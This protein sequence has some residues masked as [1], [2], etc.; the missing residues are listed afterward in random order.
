MEFSI[1]SH[2]PA[3]KDTVWGLL[4]R[5]DTLVF[6]A[7]GMVTY[8]GAG[9]FP[10]HWELDQPVNL[11]PS[12]FGWLPPGDHTVTFT[13][14]Q[15]ERGVLQTR[16]RGGP[17]KKW[18]H[19]MTVEPI[20]LATCRYTDHIVFDAGWLNPLAHVFVR[21]FYRHRHR[22]WSLL[23]ERERKQGRLT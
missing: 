4:Q 2:L 14:R 5:S 22:R 19:R 20:D 23:L 15:P 8:Q 12:L 16:E 6:L 17:F 18:N 9:G 13:Y 21:R 7:D 3:D 10:E 1:T 11:R